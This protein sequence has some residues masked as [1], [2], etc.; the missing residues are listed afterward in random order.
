MA[1]TSITNLDKPN[2]L[3]VFLIAGAAALGGFLFGYDTAVI[4]GAVAALAKDFKISS[5][6]T[7]LA[8]SLALLGATVGAFYAGK[9][10]D[11][12]GR[13]RAMVIAA[14]LFT[15]SAIGSGFAFSIWDFIFWRLLG[16]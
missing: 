3:Y 7:G 1:T 15:I 14:T 16:D 10:A 9:I 13:V 12:Y 6:M 5:W 4:N 2:T 11:R 8:V